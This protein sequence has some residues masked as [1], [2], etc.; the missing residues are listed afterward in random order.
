[1]STPHSH[2]PLE[3]AR[4][5][6]TIRRQVAR[7]LGDCD[8]ATLDDLTQEGLILLLRLSRRE[9]L[10]NPTGAALTVATRVAVDEIRRRCRRRARDVA[11][12]AAHL[13]VAGPPDGAA[14]EAALRWSALVDLLRVHHPAGHALAQ[15]YIEHGDWRSVALALGRGHDAVRQQWARCMARCRAAVQKDPGLRELLLERA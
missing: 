10:R 8:A 2:E 4:V 5:Q 14:D 7:R 12:V 6:T 11:W 15:A 1:M 3:W 13:D 9:P